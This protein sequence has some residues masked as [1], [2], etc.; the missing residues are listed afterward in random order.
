MLNTY[1]IMFGSTAIPNPTEYSQS[2]E[3]IEDVNETEAGT[4]IV[5]ISRRDKLTVSLSFNVSSA[6]AK[7]FETFRDTE[8][9][10]VKLYDAKTGAYKTRSM[11]IRN[12]KTSLVDDSWNTPNTNGLYEVSFEL[13]EY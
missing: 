13:K 5:I 6:W 8:P 11:R 9:I 10:S 12:Y 3:V 7:R 2:S 1:P 4:D